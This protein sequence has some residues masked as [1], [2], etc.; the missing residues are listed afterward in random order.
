MHSILPFFN[1]SK[2]RKC[3]NFSRKR[4]FFIANKD[5]IL[6]LK[7]NVRSSMLHTSL[8]IQRSFSLGPLMAQPA[9]PYPVFTSSQ[10]I[11]SER[12]L[13]VSAT[14]YPI[15]VTSGV[16]GS[17]P[18]F[19]WTHLL[20]K[21]VTWLALMRAFFIMPCVGVEYDEPLVSIDG[22]RRKTTDAAAPWWWGW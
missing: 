10:P 1:H 13:T 14:Y 8:S 3:T 4:L 20:R 15:A 6:Y 5:I 18:S 19:L 22:R 16:D 21:V 12:S 2:K 7:S 9:A 17:W 11:V